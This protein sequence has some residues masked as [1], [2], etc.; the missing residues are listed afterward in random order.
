MRAELTLENCVRR[1][2]GPLLFLERKAEVGLNARVEVLDH[3][4]RARI[5]RVAAIDDRTF[6]IEVLES[7]LGL[8]VRDTRIRIWNE[9]LLFGVGPGMLGRTYDSIGQ[10]TDGGAP[11]A[12]VRRMRIDGLAINPAVR[13]LPRD[14]IETGIS[15]IDLMNSLVRGQKLP[16]FSGSGLPHDRLATDIV[17][18]AR[19]RQ[20]AQGSFAVVFVGMGVSH[21]TAE[22]F[23]NAMASSGALEHTAMFLNLADEPSTQRLLT[24]RYALTAAEYLAFVEGRHVLVVMTDMTNYC[25]ALR[26]VSASHG[27]LPS[28]KGYPGYMYSDLASLY[29]RAG[30]IRALPGSL[31]QLPILTMPADDI[32]H[33]IPDLTGYITEGQIVLDRELDRRGIYP[34]VRVLPSLSRLMS[35]GTGKGFTHADHPALANQLFACYAR[36]AHVGVLASVMGEDSLPE[37]DRRFLAFGREFDQRFVNQDGRRT[38]E[39]SMTLGWQLLRALPA[40]ELTRL[41]RQQIDHYLGGETHARITA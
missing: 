1:I 9:P 10:P 34:P 29:E 15:A 38:L 23:R 36:A 7:T 3:D 2:E 4:G 14:F 40:S 17:L 19:L 12:A 11:I 21:D 13:A 28:R 31:T 37:V 27:E 25:E 35:S 33:P 30:C 26:E 22:T 6:V 8:G 16:L 5:G 24:P 32:S 41:T 20:E 18:Q 39:E